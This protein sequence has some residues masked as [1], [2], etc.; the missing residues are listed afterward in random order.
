MRS[1]IRIR[2]ARG[3]PEVRQAL[4]RYAKWLRKRYVFPIRV[5]VYL[6][7][8]V[9][10]ITQDGEHVSASFFAPWDPNEEPFIRIATGDYESLKKKLGRNDALAAFIVSL[11]HE[12][13]HYFQWIK[14]GEISEKGVAL[15]SR[16]MLRKYASEVRRP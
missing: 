3:H 13:N 7:P 2:G 16:A 5:P 12:V 4:V 8:S 15:K 1:G 11:S 6:F 9:T 14:S 10:I